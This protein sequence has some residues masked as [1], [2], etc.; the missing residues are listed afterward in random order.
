MAAAF[1]NVVYGTH[2]RNILGGFSDRG[3]QLYVTWPKRTRATPCFDNPQARHFSTNSPTT[4]R[5]YLQ[6]H[7]NRAVCR[8]RSA[9][10]NA[11]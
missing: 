4:D 10:H 11:D 3:D 1:R 5:Q 9:T 8:H 6:R 2:L 7:E